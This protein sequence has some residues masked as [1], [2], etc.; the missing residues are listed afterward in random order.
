MKTRFFLLFSLIFQVGC[1]VALGLSFLE[2]AFNRLDPFELET[3]QKKYPQDSDLIL[4]FKAESLYLRGKIRA[5]DDL[6]SEILRNCSPKKQILC[7]LSELGFSSETKRIAL[8]FQTEKIKRAL[9]A[10]QNKTLSFEER[11]Y[12]EGRILWR[13]PEELGGSVSKSLLGWESL[14]RLRPE[15]SSA[16]FYM[17]QIYESQ[18]KQELAQNAFKQ[19]LNQ[20]PPDSRT[21]LIQTPGAIP[22]RGRFYFGVVGNPAGGAG[23]TLGRRDDRF[24]DTQ[25]KIEV[26]ISAQSRGVYSG[27][28]SYEDWESLKPLWLLGRLVAASEIDQFFGFGDQSKI[29]R[30]T[31]IDQSRS[32]GSVGIRRWFSHFYFQ[33]D[34]GWFLREPS[35]VTGAEA[36]NPELRLRQQSLIPS[37]E[38]GVQ[39]SAFDIFLQVSGA[40]KGF[41]STHSFE[42]IKIGAQKNISM[43]DSTQLTLRT[44]FRGIFGEKPFGM[45]SQLSGNVSLPGVRRGRFRDPLAWHATAEW[46]LPLWQE[47]SGE[48][49]AQIASV[50]PSGK[51]LARGPFLLG[52]GLAL[53]IGRGG[54]QSRVE[55]GNFAGETVIQTGVQLFSE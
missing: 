26:S 25:R 50:G 9:E 1:S 22:V 54:F 33:G 31:E 47:F 5:S 13:I 27:R 15:L 2:P 12:L 42:V 4:F 38:L 34:L 37:L 20:T 55:L 29:T 3:L 53:L 41:G 36:A 11:A 21:L 35:F 39:E 23:I 7:F 19:A 44:G 46:T 43:G 16:S 45:L 28:L 48:V 32:Q 40:Q 51:E 18:G 8:H 10:I 6:L 17:G 30:L 49:F 52:G 14:R 24:L